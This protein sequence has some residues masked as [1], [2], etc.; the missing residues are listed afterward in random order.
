MSS[1]REAVSDLGRPARVLDFDVE[2]RP[3]AWY[4]G[5]WVTKEITAIAWRFI[6][7][8]ADVESRLAELEESTNVWLLTP[9]GTLT[10]HLR[11]KRRGLELFLRDYNKADLVTGHFIRGFDLPLLNGA[12]IRAGLPSLGS[13]MSHDTKTD[14]I[15]MSGLSKSQEN[16]AAYFDLKH[17]KQH[18]NNHLWEIANTLVRE[19]R[20]ETRRRVAGDV[21]QHI[22]F[23]QELMDRGAL[24]PP[25][26]WRPG[27][28]SEKYHP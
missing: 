7:F 8:D 17:E 26:A 18:M 23:R 4:G 27:A 13:K 11:K 2:C 6:D 12:L 19:G 28:R 21:N 24:Q 22:E 5:D 25:S 3:S 1:F 10:Q 20:A 9:S 14:L 15:R 16:L